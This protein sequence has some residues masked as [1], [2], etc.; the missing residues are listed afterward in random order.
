MSKRQAR[1]DFPGAVIYTWRS[2]SSEQDDWVHGHIKESGNND[3]LCPGITMV[4]AVESELLILE[5][6]YDIGIRDHT[7]IFWLHISI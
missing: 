4:T 6:G 3:Y 1:K 7:F 2:T 5:P